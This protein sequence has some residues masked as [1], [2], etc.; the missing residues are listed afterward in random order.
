MQ[1]PQFWS[2]AHVIFGYRLNSFVC[3]ASGIFHSFCLHNE[4][5][6]SLY[7]RHHPLKCRISFFQVTFSCLSQMFSA[8]SKWH[9][10]LLNLRRTHFS[11]SFMVQVRSL[12]VVLNHGRYTTAQTSG[13]LTEVISLALHSPAFYIRNVGLN[14]ESEQ[15]ADIRI[16][17]GTYTFHYC[18]FCS[19]SAL[20]YV[21]GIDYRQSLNH[22]M[23][24]FFEYM[25]MLD[26]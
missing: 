20:H 21:P 17:K 8:T 6:N 2:W 13:S 4:K 5:E 14:D 10:L 15:V 3:H 23:K 22:V 26:S 16:K 19:L 9:F 11:C 24:H 1:F 25:T 18:M 7:A 12:S